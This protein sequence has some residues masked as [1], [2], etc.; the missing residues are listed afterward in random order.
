MKKILCLLVFLTCFHKMY[1]QSSTNGDEIFTIVEESPE[2]PG[3]MD[4]LS[5][6][7]SKNIEY[8]K[9]SRRKNSQ[10]KV[11]VQF[12]VDKTGEVVNTKVLRGVDKYIDA[13]ALR[14]VNKMP[15][16]KPGKQRGEPVN[17]YF[18]LPLNFGLSNK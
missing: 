5:A 17:V 15:R 1:S 8:P 10:G 11:Y 2:F 6:F 9:K 18:N 7:I 14:V 3:G 4:S 16:W 13:E 12:V